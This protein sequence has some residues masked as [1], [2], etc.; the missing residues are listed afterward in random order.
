LNLFDR[1]AGTLLGT[2]LGDVLGRVTHTDP[3]AVEGA[4]FVAEVT[5]LAITGRN[6][7]VIVESALAV[8][9]EPTLAAP[10][11]ADAENLSERLGVG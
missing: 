10:P 3:R 7:A 5:A 4:R 1:L 8:V 11:P 6:P 2:A 9:T